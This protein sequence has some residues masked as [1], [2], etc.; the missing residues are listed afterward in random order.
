MAHSLRHPMDG[1]T[2]IRNA[3]VF[4]AEKAELTGPSD[5]YV[6]RGRITAVL[7]AGSPT[8]GA[9]HEIDAGGRVLLPGLFDMHVHAGRWDGGLNIAAGV[10]TVRDMGNRNDTLQ[11]IITETAAG[12]LLPRADRPGRLSRGSE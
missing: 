11:Q 9:D 8:R 10:T 7:P 4:D 5:V 12:D 2:V 6:M 3:K 1:L